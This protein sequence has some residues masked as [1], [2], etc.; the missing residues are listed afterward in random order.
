MGIG[1]QA[2]LLDSPLLGSLWETLVF[3][4]FKRLFA[5]DVGTWQLAYWRDRTK[6]ADF[7]LHRAG[8]VMLADA[9]WTE[10]PRNAWRLASVAAEFPSPPPLAIFCRCAN[11]HPL[12]DHAEALP[13]SAL[14]GWIG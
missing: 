7:L 2:D 11:P 8:R 14:G 9:K 6:E 13:L 12:G 5:A 4:E 10:N 1:S 3:S